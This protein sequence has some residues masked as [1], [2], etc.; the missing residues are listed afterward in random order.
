MVGSSAKM[1]LRTHHC[2][3]HSAQRYYGGVP[4]EDVRGLEVGT[5][6]LEH[7]HTGQATQCA[8]D[9]SRRGRVDRESTAKHEPT[10]QSGGDCM[11]KTSEQTYDA[12][13]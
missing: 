7:A 9:Q 5:M 2:A 1:K 3:E 11:E 4:N 13:R 6:Q 12:R 8:C 10:Q